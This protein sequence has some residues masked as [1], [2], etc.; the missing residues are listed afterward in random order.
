LCRSDDPE[1]L[2]R[3]PAEQR[4]PPRMVDDHARHGEATEPVDAEVP[5]SS[6]DRTPEAAHESERGK[7]DACLFIRYEPAELT[8][9]R[10]PASPARTVYSVLARGPEGSRYV[11]VMRSSRY[12]PGA[13][14]DSSSL[15]CSCSCGRAPSDRLSESAIRAPRNI[16]RSIR[17]R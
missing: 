17:S 3:K 16:P 10:T 11:G 4:R 12:T 7:A 2:V 8:R 14:A 9:S 6:G 13:C 1:A 15:R 5:L